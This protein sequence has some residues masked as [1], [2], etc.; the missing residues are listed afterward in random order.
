MD[1]NQRINAEFDSNWIQSGIEGGCQ[2]ICTNLEHFLAEQL[3]DTW[4]DCL[5]GYRVAVLKLYLTFFLT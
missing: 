3:G 4:K 5:G 2:V 1:L